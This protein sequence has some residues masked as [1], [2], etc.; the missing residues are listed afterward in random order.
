MIAAKGRQFLTFPF[1]LALAGAG[2]TAWNGMDAASVP[3]LTEGCS[4]FQTFTIGGISLWWPGVAL[5]V[6]LLPLTIVGA[7]GAGWIISGIALGLDC[8]LMVIMALTAP[9]FSCLVVA[10]LIALIFWRFREALHSQ[11]AMGRSQR[12]TS[13]SWLLVL[14]AVLFVVNIGLTARST[15][16][17]WAMQLP[18]DDSVARVNIYFS[19]TCG[20]CRQLVLG[21]PASEAAQVA[22]YPVIEDG[23]SLSAVEAMHRSVMEG[24]PISK[25]FSNGL[26][27]PPAGAWTILVNPRLLVLQFRLWVN[28]AHVLRAGSATLP[29][30]EFRGLPEALLKPGTPP[31]PRPAAGRM[32]TPNANPNVDLPFLNF[33]SIGECTDGRTS[34]DCP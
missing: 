14:W 29:Y 6:I 21:M 2:F 18:T 23:Q 20:A 24:A 27:T 3:C 7:A 31:P 9:C 4:L 28:Q 17:P 10:A 19:P 16:T 13:R 22:W 30:I 25:A 34:P 26:E 32:S 5:F 33:Q 15:V 11:M 1:I 12:E 8:V